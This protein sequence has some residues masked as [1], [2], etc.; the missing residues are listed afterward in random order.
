MEKKIIGVIGGMGPIA[1]SHY[2]ELIIRMTDAEVDQEHLDMIIYNI[3]SIPDRTEYILDH[4][5]PNPLPEIIR[6]GKKLEEAGADYLCM[7]CITAHNFAKTLEQEF[8]HPFINIVE[9][10]AAYLNN[11]GITKAG[12]MA[13][14]GTVHS[15]LFQKAFEKYGIEPVIPSPEMQKNVMHIIYQNVK[16]NIP[17]EL[18]RFESVEKELKA[19]GAQAII[20]GC[21]ELSLVK[22]DEKIGSGFLDGMEVLAQ[23]TVR[24]C[25][26]KVK[27][28]YLELISE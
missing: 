25:G 13:T 19:N 14:D 26:C 6:I 28:K 18:D 7:P 10:T 21:T 23:T 15:G 11:K 5:K 3:P 20:L 2:M 24:L 16:A 8:T 27:E 12:I 17:A 1:T 4:S 22:R 9:E